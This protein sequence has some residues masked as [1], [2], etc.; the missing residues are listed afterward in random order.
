LG[1]VVIVLIAASLLA[2]SSQQSDTARPA[3]LAK[4][5]QALELAVKTN[6]TAVAWE[7][8]GLVRHL[9]NK[10]DSA[11][12]AFTEAVRLNPAL[13]TS[14]LFLGVGL[15]RTNQFDRALSS[16]TRADRL[17]PDAGAGR[18]DLDYWFAATQI[19]LRKPLSGARLIERLLARN[20]SHVAALELAVRTYADAS[21]SAWNEVGEKHPETAS[22]Y[23]VLGHALESE[24]NR[25]GALAAFRHAQTLNPKR[26]GPGLA[27]G[28]LLLLQGKAQEAL[29]TLKQEIALPAADSQA[30]Y[31]AGIA[32]VQLGLHADAVLWLEQASKWVRH[33]PEA[34]L[35]LAQVYLA[36]NQP[37]NAAAAARQAIA[38]AP[39]SPA[40]H[41]F[42]EAALTAA[43]LT[44]E[45]AAERRRWA[46]Q[47]KR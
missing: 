14:H 38:V 45:L 10:F 33:N 41:E 30:F 5:E 6:P 20:P 3:D 21:T 25:D 42:L 35:A 22:G 44:D 32:A 4:T 28:R 37:R 1:R 46:A 24:G 13:W 12:P 18:D 7:K 39:S 9:Q 8:L 29:D 15:Y 17:A 31:H 40:A 11:I 27:V 47:V 23:E 36:L 2:R 26:P 43:G 16:L 19:A 34:P